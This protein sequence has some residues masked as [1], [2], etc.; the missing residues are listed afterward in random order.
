MKTNIAIYACGAFTTLLLS[1]SD[2]FA[3][4]YW[5]TP[6]F[7]G[8]SRPPSVTIEGPSIDA[9][10]RSDEYT[11]LRVADTEP[12]K[13][14][15]FVEIFSSN[16]L[17]MAVL[18]PRWVYPTEPWEGS[19]KRPFGDSSKVQAPVSILVSPVRFDSAI[20][21][22]KL[23]VERNGK[24]IS[25]IVDSLTPKEENTAIGSVIYGYLSFPCAAFYPNASV[26]ITAVPH[27]GEHIVK[28]FTQEELTLIS[29]VPALK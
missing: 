10:N 23:R 15:D 9:K 5:G 28:A 14:V 7:L 3:Q 16:A 8:C 12:R 29:G 17:F 25:P 19:R 20:N 27:S 22:V 1:G 21:I 2:S 11:V 26:T 13:D 24:T 18:V 6:A 4:D